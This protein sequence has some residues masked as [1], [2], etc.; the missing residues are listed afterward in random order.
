MAVPS[1]AFPFATPYDPSEDPP[2]SVDPLGTVAEAERLADVI[3]PGLPA[4]MWR[5]RLLTFSAVS[6]LVAQA[7][8]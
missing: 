3:L 8:V 4:R 5:A 2:T 6:S 7:V 1:T